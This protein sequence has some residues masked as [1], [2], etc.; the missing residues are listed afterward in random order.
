MLIDV[1]LEDKKFCKGCLFDSESSGN[2]CDAGFTRKFSECVPA[3]KEEI[4]EIE[5]SVWTSISS[6]L[7]QKIFD[8]AWK[9]LRPQ[10]CIL[11]ERPD[12]KISGTFSNYSQV[13]RKSNAK[14]KK[15]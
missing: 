13:K 2:V 8:G 6:R 10:Q 5:E 3:K 1:K 14:R 4:E 9:V 11:T 7:K 15:D 12:K